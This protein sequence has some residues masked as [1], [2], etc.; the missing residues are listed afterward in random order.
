MYMSDPYTGTGTV[1]KTLWGLGPAEAQVTSE[2]LSASTGEAL[3]TDV[4]LIALETNYS[5]DVLQADV[6]GTLSAEIT[7]VTLDAEV[8]GT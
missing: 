7:E 6:G 5:I 4:Q 8:C 1:N 3:E 2:V